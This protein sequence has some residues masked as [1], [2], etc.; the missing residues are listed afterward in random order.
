MWQERSTRDKII[1]YMKTGIDPASVPRNCQSQQGWSLDILIRFVNPIW[2]LF[3][4][5][6][7]YTEIFIDQEVRVNNTTTT[8]DSNK[9]QL[10]LVAFF[11]R[12]E[13]TIHWNRTTHHA[14]RG[15]YHDTPTHR[16]I[17]TLN[18]WRLYMKTQL[19]S[20]YI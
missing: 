3:I 17:S 4:V 7:R 2:L 9:T 10:K 18:D 6:H 19:H 13:F 8:V 15:I 11:L 14:I 20:H 5:Q 1:D 16:W 12:F